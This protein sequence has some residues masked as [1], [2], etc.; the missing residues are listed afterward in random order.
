MAVT[1]G[2]KITVLDVARREVNVTA[3]YT[4][5]ADP[6]NPKI[7]T[8]QNALIATA[9]QKGAVLDNIEAHYN[10]LLTRDAA[11]AAFIADLETAGAANL[12]ARL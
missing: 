8:V 7:I 1:V 12:E 5:A 3:T 10:A 2:L 4:D 9:A 11:V 6:N